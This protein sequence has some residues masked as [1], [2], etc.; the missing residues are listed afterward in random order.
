M[1]GFTAT[2]GRFILTFLYQQQ[3]PS[4]HGLVTQSLHLIIDAGRFRSTQFLT[5][6]IAIDNTRRHLNDAFVSMARVSPTLFFLSS[7]HQ[8]S[9][10]RLWYGAHEAFR[11]IIPVVEARIPMTPQNAIY[12]VLCYTPFIFLSYLARRPDTYLIRLLWLPTVITAILVAA[13]R[14]YWPPEL[15]GYN[16][17]QRK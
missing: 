3:S 11:T 13:Y 15:N 1:R 16:W 8:I 6:L 17:V 9:Y 10:Y 7:D 4:G 2:R 12:P 14:F 5:P